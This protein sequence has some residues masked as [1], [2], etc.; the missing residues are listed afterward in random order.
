MFKKSILFIG[1]LA[2]AVMFVGVRTTY[3]ALTIGSNSI[4]TS[5]TLNLAGGNIGIATAS[6]TQALDVTG[7]GQFSGVIGLGTATASADVLLGGTYTVAPSGTFGRGINLTLTGATASKIYQGVNVLVSNTTAAGTVFAA[8]GGAFAASHN[9]ASTVSTL[10]GVQGNF[11]INSGPATN[12]VGLGTLV[13][14]NSPGSAT[15]TYG[16]RAQM[17]F[18]AGATS[19]NLT[20]FLFDGSLNAGGT[21]TTIK[22]IDLGNWGSISSTTSYG[23]FADTGIDK[24]ATSYFIYSTSASPSYI[25]GQLSVGAVPTGTSKLVVNGNMTLGPATSHIISSQTTPPVA[26]PSITGISAAACTG[27]TDTRGVITTTGTPSAT[28]TVTLAFNTAY[29]AAPVVTI[30]PANAAAQASNA[31]VSSTSTAN[32][33]IT[34]TV[35]APGATPSWYY[36]VMQ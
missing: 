34:T 20:G 21:A 14:I 5:T 10:T 22:G 13:A 11:T 6:P 35:A 7:N 2:M 15:N 12:A 27:C 28:G 9:G 29:G 1:L 18:G 8:T 17:G 23:I 4:S 36:M 24:G 31:Y 26:T 30:T 19:T 33:V 32:F 25:N 16:V 3:A